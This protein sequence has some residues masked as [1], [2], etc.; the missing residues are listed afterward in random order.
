[1]IKFTAT[2]ERFK[3]K[4]EKTGWTIASLPDSVYKKF[5]RPDKKEFRVKGFID[6]VAVEKLVVYPIGHGEFILA[7]NGVLRKKLGKE[8]GD[9]IALRLEL[10]EA[11]GLRS[12]EMIEALKEDGVAW[13]A[14]QA[15]KVSH[16]N[17]FHRHVANAKRA[18][19]KAGRIIETIMA[20]HQ[21]MDFGEMIRAQKKNKI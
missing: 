15:L 2:L 8:A 21:G 19:T 10:D 18:D 4:G 9:T 14:F 11:G 3:N 20:M 13:L 1:M 16:Q 12:P 7:L 17:Y 5:K 6:D